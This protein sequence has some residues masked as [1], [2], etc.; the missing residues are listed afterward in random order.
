MGQ[1]LQA[2]RFV[3][4][5][6]LVCVLAAVGD[7]ATNA[8]AIVLR[9]GVDRRDDA[10]HGE[11]RVEVVGGHDQRA[12]GVLERGGEAAA[13]DVAQHVEDHDVGLFEQVMLLEELHGLAHDVAAATG[14]GRRSAGLDAHDAVVALEH[15]VLGAQFLGMEIDLF[16]DVDHGRD[17][18][19]W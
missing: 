17:Q 8:H 9:L 4:A 6:D 19:T 15:E 11:D 12:V 5:V 13:H 3:E 2:D 18:A 10:V 14:A 1:A 16:E 7:D